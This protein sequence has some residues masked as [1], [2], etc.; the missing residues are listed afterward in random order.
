MDLS[1]LSYV[2]KISVD[3]SDPYFFIMSS[4]FAKQFFSGKE[5]L[6]CGNLVFNNCLLTCLTGYFCH[7][8]IDTKN[9]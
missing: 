4:C 7:F 2:L 8:L 9:Q 6:I 3:C 1:S 5:G